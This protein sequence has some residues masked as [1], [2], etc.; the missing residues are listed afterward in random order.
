MSLT[1]TKNVVDAIKTSAS[2]Y[3]NTY[4]SEIRTDA[5]L[6]LAELPDLEGF[7]ISKNYEN[8]TYKMPT[9]FIFHDSQDKVERDQGDRQLISYSFGVTVK[10]NPNE[11]EIAYNQQLYYLDA[12]KRWILQNVNEN[13]AFGEYDGC[14]VD[15]S[16]QT[17]KLLYILFSVLVEEVYC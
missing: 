13:E 4:I 10:L 12:I 17:Y 7:E 11:N 15:N 2:T 3:I 1:E 5:G 16:R 14:R 8:T 6:T 9:I